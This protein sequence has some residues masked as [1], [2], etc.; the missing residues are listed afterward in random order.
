MALRLK[1][2]LYK[3]TGA[4]HLNNNTVYRYRFLIKFYAFGLYP[5]TSGRIFSTSLKAD[6][7]VERKLR[8]WTQMNFI[9]AAGAGTM[10]GY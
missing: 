10:T 4:L 9:N 3:Y 7:F 8:K 2:F 1:R 6:V 5:E